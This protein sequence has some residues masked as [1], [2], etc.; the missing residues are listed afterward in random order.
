MI[1][2][3]EQEEHFI[4]FDTDTGIEYRLHQGGDRRIRLIIESVHNGNEEK[5][6]LYKDKQAIELWLQLGIKEQP[7]PSLSLKLRTF[8]EEALLQLGVEKV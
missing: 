5:Y 3:T 8:L 6:F 4:V 1:I 7:T 2:Y